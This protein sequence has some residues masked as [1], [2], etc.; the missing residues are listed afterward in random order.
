[1]TS[2]TFAA[3]TKRLDTAKH[4]PALRAAL[5]EQRRLRSEQLDELAAAAQAWFPSTTD[6]PRDQVAEVLRTGASIAL[7]EI[8]AALDRL[9]NGSYGRCEACE[10][11]IPLERL[12][13]LP[14]ASLCMRCQRVQETHRR[15]AERGAT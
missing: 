5:E 2:L 15:R 11:V 1:M 8:E 14:M 7:S 13:I 10:G 12:E 6:E 9:G 4:L 3:S